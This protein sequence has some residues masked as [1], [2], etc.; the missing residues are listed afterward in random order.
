MPH[1]SEYNGQRHVL[2]QVSEHICK[3]QHETDNLNG[4]IT[5]KETELVILKLPKKKSP[6]LGSVTGEFCQVFKEELTP[7]L[8]VSSRKQKRR[9]YAPIHLIP[10][11]AKD[12]TKKDN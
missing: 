10:K 11:L 9:E 12:C 2:T 7:V 5:N 6:G 8:H 3:T 1:G 4:P